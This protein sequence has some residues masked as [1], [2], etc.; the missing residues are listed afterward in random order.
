MEEQLLPREELAPSYE[1][2]IW[3]YV[4]RDFSKRGADLAAERVSLR[5]GFTSY[6][7]HHLLHP[8]T[9]KRITSTGRS[10]ESFLA[11]IE[12]S[13]IGEIGTTDALGRIEAA[14][15]RAAGLEK[16]ASKKDAIAALDEDPDIVVKYRAVEILAEKARKEIVKR[17]ESLLALP[18]DPLRYLVCSA[19]EKEADADAAPHLEA[20]VK[21]PKDSLNPN[22]LRINAVKALSECGDLA[23]AEAI[24]PFAAGSWRNGLTRISIAALAR[25]AERKRKTKKRI[26]ALLAAAYPMPDAAAAGAIR[27]QAKLLHKALGDVAGRKVKFPDTYDEKARARLMATW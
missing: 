15:R 18:N 17:A 10:V 11:A 23:A 9:L 25:I 4:Y 6:P 12:K 21:D 8:V 20:L 16:K 7:Q 13:A 3:L 2:A 5:L 1:K 24:A 22:V 14:E 19:L 27:E 26:V